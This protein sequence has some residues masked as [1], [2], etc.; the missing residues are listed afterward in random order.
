MQKIILGLIALLLPVALVHGGQQ[1]S[2]SVALTGS[3]WRDI[4]SF[5][6][7]DMHRIFIH[8]PDAPAPKNG[9][10]VV[11][12]LDGNAYFPLVVQ[13]SRLLAVRPEATGVV[14]VIVVGIGYPGASLHD[15]QRRAHDYTPVATEPSATATGG[16]D[17]FL[18][19]ITDELQPALARE[20]PIDPHNQT[21]LGHSYGGLFVVHTLLN[22]PAAFQ[23]YIA[24]SPSIWFADRAVL[25]SEAGLSDRI[26]QPSQPLRVFLSAGE[27][28]Q[29]LDPARPMPPERADKLRQNRMIDNARELAS[30]LSALPG[31]PLRV[32]FAEYPSENHASIVPVS[33]PRALAFV[34]QAGRIETTR[35]E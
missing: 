18:R 27:Y 13:V 25:K 29:T 7:K 17:A 4:P 20:F 11:Y 16:A 5:H 9:F 14:P 10:P 35:R 34:L 24:I 33:L 32:Q 28:E 3:E 19:F 2:H 15:S 21:L 26:G 23:N 8:R 31:S 1:D 22:R 12:V 6:T 30:H